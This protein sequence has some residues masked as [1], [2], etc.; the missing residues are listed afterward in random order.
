MAMCL[1][2]EAVCEITC[3]P[4]RRFDLDAAIIFSDIL[5]IPYAL[6]Q[7]VDFIEGKG[8]IL[9]EIP[10]NSLNMDHF[11]EKIEP[12]LEGIKLTRKALPS[13]KALI[14]FVGAPWTLATYIIGKS[15]GKNFNETIQFSLNKP[16]EFKELIELLTLSCINLLMAQ[17][18]AGVDTIQLFD[19]W[20]ASV[21]D[22]MV[23]DVVINP[24]LKITKSIKEKY[25]DIPIISFPKGLTYPL[26]KIVE[27]PHVDCV[28]F[29]SAT[30]LSVI[31]N[32]QKTKITQGNLDPNL[33]LTGG[34]LLERHVHNIIENLC[35]DSRHIFNLGHGVLPTTPIAHIEKTIQL[36]RS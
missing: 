11:S 15:T 22:F 16:E 27:N 18:E 13:S 9:E 14:G 3:Q 25:P 23:E 2:P 24:L 34:A 6:G 33:L 4:I 32:I 17:I 29:D 12:V 8:P 1:S 28:S 19:S 31:Q 5:T 30:P 35:R 36:I 7:G 21:P 10:L 20:A 26:Q